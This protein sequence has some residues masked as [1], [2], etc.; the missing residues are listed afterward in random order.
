ML[1]KILLLGN[2]GRDPEVKFT[3]QGNRYAQISVV[4]VHKYKDGSGER[5]EKLT[6]H[7]ILLFNHLAETAL[8]YLKKGN[9]IYIEGRVD[10]TES[11]EG[12]KYY[13]V[14]ASEFKMLS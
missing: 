12:I 10:I 3:N 8:S 5:L 6:W 9:L 1:N 2:L 14:I 4:T 7:K 11:K 13:S